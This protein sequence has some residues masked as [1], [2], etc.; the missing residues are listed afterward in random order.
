MGCIAQS[1]LQDDLNCYDCVIDELCYGRETETGW[2]SHFPEI[3]GRVSV[4]DGHRSQEIL[5]SRLVWPYLYS[6]LFLLLL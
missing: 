4:E 1:H 6:H 3:A 2:L 5:I